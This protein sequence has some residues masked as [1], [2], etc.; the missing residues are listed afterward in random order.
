MS[1]Y[2]VAFAKTG[3]PNGE[4]R[5]AWPRYGRDDQLLEFSADGKA[6]ACDDPWRERLDLVEAM[7][8]HP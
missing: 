3:D 4:G 5:T 1:G 7:Q 2:W 6:V 8:A